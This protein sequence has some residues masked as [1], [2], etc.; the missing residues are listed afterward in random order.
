MSSFDEFDDR[1]QYFF[2]G[3]NNDNVENFFNNGLMSS[4]GNSITSTMYPMENDEIEKLGLRAMEQ[5]YC[6]QYGFKYCYAIKIPNYYMG[7]MIHRDNSIEVPIPLWI[8]TDKISDV[9]C[10][11]SIFCPHL[12]CGVYRNDTQQVMPNPN[13]NPKYNPNGMQFAKE[14]EENMLLTSHPDYQQW[15]NFSRMRN[16]M[17]FEE[18]KLKDEKSGFWIP[19]LERYNS[20]ITEQYNP[21]PANIK[22]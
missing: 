20:L 22:K 6:Q 3:T 15:L 4:R 7:W 9:N 1:F 13:Y 8:P 19:H 11:V 10:P 17:K 5:R 21:R 16:G 2:H 18:L 12:I 14:Q